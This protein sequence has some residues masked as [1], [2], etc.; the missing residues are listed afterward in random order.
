MT[1]PTFPARWLRR[2]FCGA[3]LVLFPALLADERRGLGRRP[4]ARRRT[5]GAER[6]SRRAAASGPGG[7]PRAAR[8]AHCW[9]TEKTLPAGSLNQ[10]IRGPP[11]VMMPRSSNVIPS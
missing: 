9:R 11:P 8:G 4:P 5:A 10:A 6:L 2:Y 7:R 3:A 1:V